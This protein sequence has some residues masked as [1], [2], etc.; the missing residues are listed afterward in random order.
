[1]GP[2]VAML[3]LALWLLCPASGIL[4]E[5][6]WTHPNRQSMLRHNR[7]NLDSVAAWEGSPFL[8]TDATD[9]LTGWRAL[10]TWRNISSLLSSLSDL[11]CSSTFRS[12]V[13]VDVMHAVGDTD[14]G[15]VDGV[16]TTYA[17]VLI[18]PERDLA[19]NSILED[20]MESS[21][22]GL[23]ISTDECGG[24]GKSLID[25]GYLSRPYFVDTRR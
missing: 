25:L 8:V 18:G 3:G 20:A 21:A 15:G 16:A 2:L 6:G 14:G 4:E 12:L 23:I 17:D 13:D 10:S 24:D 11:S 22:G 5:K 19:S 7:S 9:N 1:M